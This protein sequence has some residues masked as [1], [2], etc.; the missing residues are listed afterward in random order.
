MLALR[1][2]ALIGNSC[3]FATAVFVPCFNQWLK[4]L[5]HFPKSKE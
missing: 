5:R 4:L 3:H 1:A 2:P